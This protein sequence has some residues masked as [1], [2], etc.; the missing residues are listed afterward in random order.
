MA[1]EHPQTVANA[2]EFVRAVLKDGRY[3]STYKADPRAVA[4]ALGIRITD[5]IAA[6]VPMLDV[7]QLASKL[8]PVSLIGQIGSDAPFPPTKQAGET[9]YAAKKPQTKPDEGSAE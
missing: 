7:E 6:D 5:Q 2:E 9:G 1:G 4:D 8:S 3:V